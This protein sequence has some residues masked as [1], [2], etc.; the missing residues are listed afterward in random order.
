MKYWDENAQAY[1]ELGLRGVQGPPGPAGDAI[2]AGHIMAFGGVSPATG[3]LMCDGSAVLR[4]AYPALFAAI[5]TRF[6]AG[7]GSTTFNLPNL[8][9]RVPVGASGT[10]AVGS[11][12]GESAH[13]TT[14]TE[15]PLH[16]HNGVTAGGTTG[17]GTSGNTDVDHYH[18]GTTNAADRSLAHDHTLGNNAWAT[19]FD[20]VVGSGNYAQLQTV[21]GGAAWW[22]GANWTNGQSISIDHL[23]SFTT[24]WQSQQYATNNHSHSIPGLSVPGLGIAAQGGGAAHNNMQ[25]YVAMNYVIKY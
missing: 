20:R 7:D 15:L 5:S 25:P 24:N 14:I 17:G 4:S 3:W 12:G 10:K 1:V 8:Q 16:S 18:A 23:H 11:T 9:D 21:S 22:S 13:T 6:G 19:L 2:P